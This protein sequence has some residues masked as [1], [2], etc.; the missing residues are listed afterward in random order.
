MELPTL[1]LLGGTYLGWAAVTAYAAAL[2]PL[3]AV[4][5]LGV[6]LAQHSSLQHEAIH[7]HPTRS[8][9]LND[10]LV[11]PALGL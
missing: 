7:G 2:G 5:L 11:F 8:R 1:L 10:A 9:R 4:P 6:L 3:L